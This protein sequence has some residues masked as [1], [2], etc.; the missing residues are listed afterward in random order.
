MNRIATLSSVILATFIGF[1]GIWYIHAYASVKHMTQRVPTQREKKPD[2]KEAPVNIEG[3]LTTY[4]GEPSAI[5]ETWPQFRGADF[6]NIAKDLTPLA[7]TWPEQGPPVVWTITL[8]QGY[9]GAVVHSGRVYVMDYDEEKGGDALR[10]FS[11]DDGREIWR[12]FYKVKI[13]PWHG[14][15]RTVPATDGKHVVSIGPMCQ[16]MCCDAATGAFKWGLDMMREYNTPELDWYS[17]Q[18]PL[19]DN[20]KAI[21]APGADVLMLARDCETGEVLWETPNPGEWKISHAS[22]MP[23]TF[24]GKKMYVY[25]AVGGLVGVSAEGADAGQILWDSDAWTYK[26]IAPSPVIFDDGRIFCTAGYGRGS[27]MLR[28]SQSENGYRAESL[29][30]RPMTV[31]AC[32]QQTP[33]HYKD[34]LFTVLPNDAKRLRKHF[35]CMTPEGEVRWTSGREYR[36]GL[37]P[38][39]VADGKFLI[40]DDDGLLTMAAATPEAFRPIT[41]AHVLDGHEAWAPM[42]LVKG[43]LILRDLTTMKCL[44][45]RAEAE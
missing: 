38:Y 43:R 16:V 21:L 9:A 31:F 5:L 35:V 24:K 34:H 14:I 25:S 22:I 3:T 39:M 4:D 37:G 28:L 42:A 41:Q 40:L 17:G 44:D 11:L 1:A 30:T 20:G 26:V 45:L 33:I 36:F 6:D 18:C 15:S 27:M 23:M 29:Y 2:K 7:D 19:L 13:K 32:E 8:G 10:C 12:R